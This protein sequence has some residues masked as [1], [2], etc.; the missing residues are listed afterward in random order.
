MKIVGI[1]DIHGNHSIEARNGCSM[2]N[3]SILDEEYKI[4]Y[5]PFEFEI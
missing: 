3:V 1:S 5:K 2:V 4:N